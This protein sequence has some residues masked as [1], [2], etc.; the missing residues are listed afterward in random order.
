VPSQG[1]IIW[2][3]FNPTL[4]REQAGRRPA[5]VIS[6]TEY[7]TK[8]ELAV[9]CPITGQ[10]RPLRMRVP[11][12]NRT[13]TQGDV[14]CEQIRTIDLQAR[15]FKIVERIPDDIL[16]HIISIITLLIEYSNNS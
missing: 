2:L 6:Q 12:D 5:L 15:Q 16:L 3:D 7:N 14:I 9:V 11:L 13:A 1:D 8:R 4:G 10:Q